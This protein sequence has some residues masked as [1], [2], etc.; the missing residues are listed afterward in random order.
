MQIHHVLYEH[1]V[2][3]K[4]NPA[5]K[6][7]RV[8]FSPNLNLFYRENLSKKAEVMSVIFTDALIFDEG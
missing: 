3:Q 4:K 6:S 8:L 1:S 7:A 2:F 5:E